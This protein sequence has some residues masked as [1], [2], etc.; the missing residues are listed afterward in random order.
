MLE[1]IPMRRSAPKRLSF[2]FM[3]MSL[4]KHPAMLTA[5]DKPKQI[6]AKNNAIK[7]KRDRLKVFKFVYHETSC[8]AMSSI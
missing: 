4:K 8:T 1:L 7:I 2:F 5:K 6:P 3:G